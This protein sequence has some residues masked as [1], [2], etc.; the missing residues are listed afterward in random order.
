MQVG[1]STA[2]LFLKK[3]NEEAFPLFHSLGVKYAEVFFTSF[4]EYGEKFASIMKK[5]QGDIIVNSIHALNTQF[6]PQLYSEHPKVSED[7]FSVL[8]NF[9]KGGALL[10][11]KYY[12]FHG[13]ARIKRSSNYDRYLSSPVHSKI[14]SFCRKYGIT[15]CYE[16]VEWALYNRPSLFKIIKESYPDIMGVLDIKQARLSGYSYA[17]YIN[18]MAGSIAHVH[19][20]DI[21]PDGKMCLPGKGCFD[22]NDLFKRL[23]D[24][25]FDGCVLIE[26]YNRDYAN[27]SEIALSCDF[28]KETLYRLGFLN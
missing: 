21:S 23:A 2:S 17:D 18:D 1:V 25:G 12:T 13:V 10:G 3:N 24:A 26:A 15:L 7:A 9:L 27:L 11:A 5:E 20:S 28:L 14:F 19:V 8:D 6:E 16:N 4:Q 22:F